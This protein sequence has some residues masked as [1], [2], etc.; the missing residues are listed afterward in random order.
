MDEEEHP[1]FTHHT[2]MDQFAADQAYRCPIRRYAQIYIESKN[3][4]LHFLIT[5][6][7]IRGREVKFV[8]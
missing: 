8:F 1:P 6:F 5:V 3:Y 4:T 7:I 2:P